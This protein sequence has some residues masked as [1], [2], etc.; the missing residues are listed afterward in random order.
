MTL[1]Y[2]IY[3]KPLD[4]PLKNKLEILN[5]ICILAMSYH[6]FLF[7]DFVD[8]NQLSFLLGWI[9]MGIT[10]INILVNLSIILFMSAAGVFKKIKN[11][12]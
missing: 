4:E 2:L 3:V 9:L 1:S 6:L 7:T 8:S 5:E 12:Y 11:A 10:G